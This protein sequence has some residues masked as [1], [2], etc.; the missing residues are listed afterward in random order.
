M[1][2]Q[3]TE[4]YP[5]EYMVRTGVFSTVVFV[6]GGLLMLI[7]PIIYTPTFPMRRVEVPY[8]TVVAVALFIL[9]VLFA[10]AT[11]SLELERRQNISEE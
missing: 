6:V 11:I 2:E 1:S 9:A 8:P 10:A 3:G 5:D 7:R 4:Q